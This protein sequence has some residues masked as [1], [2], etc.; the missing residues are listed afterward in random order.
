[1]FEDEVDD[2]I[3]DLVK[4]APD[5]GFADGTCLGT[6]K[7][8]TAMGYSHRH[9]VL[10]DGPIE[11][12]AVRHLFGCRRA[13]GAFVDPDGDAVV[14]TTWVVDALEVMDPQAH[15]DDIQTARH[16]LT[17]QGAKD[18]GFKTL[19]NR[20]RDRVASG[21]SPVD[22]AKAFLD[23]A[24]DGDVGAKVDGLLG[25]VA[26]QVV[27]HELDTGKVQGQDGGKFGKVAQQGVNFLLTQQNDGVFFVKTDAG[28][29]PDTGLSALALAALQTKPEA[30]RT[31]QEQAVI[32]AGL[33][34]LLSEQNDDGSFSQRNSNYTTCA[35]MLALAKANRPEF[36]GALE[37]A[38]HYILAIQNVESHGY[39]RSDKDYGS[40][41][42]GDDQRGDLSNLQFAVEALRASGLKAD[43][44]A[45]AKAIVFLQRTQN[46]KSVNDF[47]AR[48][49]NDDGEWQRV[50]SGDD[51]G[52]VYYPGD[53]NAGYDALGDG[54][55]VPRSY[56]S[57]TYALLKTY[58]L[59]G[60]QKDDP[61]VQAAVQWI[62][63]NWTVD[64]NPGASP[65]LPE[66]AKY[67]GLFYYYMVMAQALDLAG[68]DTL[69][70]PAADGNVEVDWRKELREKLT[71]L[72]RD[73]GS[74][75]ND[76]NGR[77]WENQPI[78][79]T[80]DA[81]VAL[82]HTRS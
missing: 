44:E 4:S 30:M 49:K 46:L 66:D 28:A 77:W 81:L 51:G 22:V 39:A 68:V 38:Q 37:K 13:D 45:F 55:R 31:D 5:G 36:K 74:W 69:S 21:E 8:L 40:I 11:R 17:Q 42:Y 59:A 6:A 26:S 12:N 53:S 2:L 63:K 15:A 79:C 7:V 64:E 48:V 29:F 50:T 24:E 3:A 23:G 56:G 67:Q 9:Y 73:D 54:R 10:G 18:G 58:T 72:Q 33:K 70:V 19:V 76:K 57:M 62:Q 82:E 35:S 71:S 27:A 75:V 78:M 1:M 32:D 61:R 65:A 14:T 16:W 80:I 20:V 52:A 25:A 43:D 41:G 34:H 47:E 60:I